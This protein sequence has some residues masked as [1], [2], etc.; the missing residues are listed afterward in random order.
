ML[1]VALLSGW[2][3]HTGGYAEYI[4]K[5]PD[6]ELTA[7]WDDDAE[8][9]KMWAEKLGIAYESDLDALLAR[10]DVDAVL[11][12]AP[13]SDHCKLLVRCAEAGKH[14]FTEK[15]LAPTVAECEKV[16]DAVRKAGVKFCISFPGLIS[17]AIQYAKKAM[18]EGKLGQ[19][20]YVRFRNAHGGSCQNWLPAYWYDKEKAGGGAMMDLGCHPNYEASYLLG[21]PKRINSMFNTNC[22]PDSVEDNAVSVI[23]FENKAIAVVETGFVSPYSNSQIEIH[24]TKGSI[25]IDGAKVTLTNE[26]GTLTPRLPAELPMALRQWIDGILYGKE[27]HFGLEG[28]IALTELLENE[29]KADREGK[30]IEL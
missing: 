20:T 1:K 22:C 24:G 17:P 21:K 10:D 13:T 29:Y 25:V 28:A 12:D 14:I 15:A 7:I 3:V 11:C 26:E 18:D 8:R 23:E 16:A 27:I 9:G 30:T 2:H 4:Q 19:V 6:A 5:Q